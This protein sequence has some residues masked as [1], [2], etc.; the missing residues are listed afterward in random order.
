MKI[1]A[2][3]TWTV[4]CIR[5]CIFLFWFDVEIQGR[6]WSSSHTF[7]RNYWFSASRPSFTVQWRTFRRR[8]R[9]RY[10]G[11]VCFH[12][13]LF[14]LCCF[15]C[16]VSLVFSP[17]CVVHFVFFILCPLV[18]SSICST[19]YPWYCSIQSTDWHWILLCNPA[20]CPPRPPWKRLSWLPECR[21][22]PT[23]PSASKPKRTL[24]PN[25][26]VPAVAKRIP[27]NLASRK[28]LFFCFF[29][30]NTFALFKA[31]IDWLS[32]YFFLGYFF[33]NVFLG[34][35]MFS[36]FHLSSNTFALFK[37]QID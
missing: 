37:A 20:T 22:C 8:R 27:S 36:I 26:V 35:C 30:P 15:S 21:S 18:L 4:E 19:F 1:H 10:Q 23:K 28:C 17:S 12:F 24:F 34:K 14:I 9:R 25:P 31:Q 13:V 29:W 33:Q 16:V 11:K 2:R 7:F 32:F 5:T 3:I 6:V